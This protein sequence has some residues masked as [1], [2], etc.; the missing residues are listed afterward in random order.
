MLRRIFQILLVLLLLLVAVA[1]LRLYSMP[2]EDEA[3]AQLRF[4]RSSLNDGAAERMQ[5]MFPEGYFFMH[6][7]YGAAWVEVG[8]KAELDSPLRKEAIAE[9]GWAIDRLESREGRVPFQENL[10]PPFG[11]FHAGWTNWLRGGWLSLYREDARPADE[12][13]RFEDSSDQLAAA[14]AKRFTPFLESYPGKAWPVDSVVAIASLRLH[15]RL[16]PARFADVRSRWREQVLARLDPA[17]GL[18]PHRVEPKAGTPTEGARGSSQALL[19][20]F[21]VEIDPD[22]GADHYRRF[23]AHFVPSAWL[24]PGTREYPI[25]QDGSSDV[26]SG[27]LFL[28]VS[29]SASAVSIAPAGLFGDD[30]LAEPYLHF[31]EALGLPLAWNG[32]RRYLAGLLPIADAFYVYGHTASAWTDKPETIATDPIL[33]SGWRL[34]W[35]VLTLGP[36]ACLLWLSRRRQTR[37]GGA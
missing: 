34:L 25:G 10:D 35:H 9:A 6:A 19:L 3:V 32:E 8:R 31:G 1:N 12:L 37:E 33:P 15:D 2:D 36:I 7:L 26:D 30:G 23:R 24:L 22:F 27:P 28:G 18:I 20:R 14:F 17:T 11:V 29:L 5:G 4:L 21:L 16:R 13:Q